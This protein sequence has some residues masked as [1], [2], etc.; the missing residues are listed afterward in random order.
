MIHTNLEYMVEE[1]LLR[2]QLSVQAIA[3]FK[4][5]AGWFK[6]NVD[7]SEIGNPGVM[8]CGGVLRDHLGILISVFARHVG[9]MINSSVCTP[10][11][12][13]AIIPRIR[14]PLHQANLQHQH[15]YRE[16]NIISDILAK[17]GSSDFL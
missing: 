2:R 17:I 10:W 9:H 14:G 8:C 1:I 15:T 7:G 5:I 16:A 12:L 6:L 3:W 13:N 4:Q 11:H